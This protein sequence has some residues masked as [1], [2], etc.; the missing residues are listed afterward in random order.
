MSSFEEGKGN[1]LYTSMYISIEPGK[2]GLCMNIVMCTYVYVM[3]LFVYMMTYVHV[4]MYLRK[5]TG[6]V[7]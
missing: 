3:F 5:Y 6:Y 7:E 2:G 1:S 4:Y